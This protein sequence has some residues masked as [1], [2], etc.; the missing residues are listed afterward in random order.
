MISDVT[1]STVN[2]LIIVIAA[3]VSMFMSKNEHPQV[4]LGTRYMPCS[5]QATIL[6]QYSYYPFYSP[7]PKP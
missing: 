2:D 7:N 1:I 4:T 3:F 5:D 6:Q